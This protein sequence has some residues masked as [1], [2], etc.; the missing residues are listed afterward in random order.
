MNNNSFK[1]IFSEEY[2]GYN[3][4]SEE[5]KNVKKELIVNPQKIVVKNW[6]EDY[7]SKLTDIFYDNSE[8][9]KDL[10]YSN[11]FWKLDFSVCDKEFKEK[12]ITF[13]DKLDSWDYSIDLI[14]NNGNLDFYSLIKINAYD[15]EL[16][17][18]DFHWNDKLVWDNVM[19]IPVFF[20]IIKNSN[21]PDLYWENEY[22]IK[23]FKD[24]FWLEV[25]NIIDREDEEYDDEPSI[26][27]LQINQYYWSNL[28][29]E[30]L[31]SVIHSL[32]LSNDSVFEYWFSKNKLIDFI[33]HNTYNNSWVL[34]K[35]NAE[36]ILGEELKKYFKKANND[37]LKTY[38]YYSNLSDWARKY[39]LNELKERYLTWK[40]EYL[41]KYSISS[42]KNNYLKSNI[43]D[44]TPNELETFPHFIKESPEFEKRILEENKDN[45][46][47]LSTFRRLFWNNLIAVNESDD[48]LKRTDVYS[49]FEFMKE[50]LS[51][52]E[53]I[54]QVIDDPIL[55]QIK[56]DI[57]IITKPLSNEGEV[58][59][60]H[61]TNDF[62]S[63]DAYLITEEWIINPE[64][65]NEEASFIS[66]DTSTKYQKHHNSV[67]WNWYKIIRT[68]SPWLYYIEAWYRQNWFW[69][70]FRNVV[71]VWNH[72]V[73]E[74]EIETLNT[75]LNK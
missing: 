39:A 70:N 14:L 65:T 13:F 66:L 4:S 16:K 50:K 48:Y 40:N 41:E 1:N 54:L 8:E 64:H 10:L 45:E 68:S 67:R 58:L 30:E 47:V 5:I 34:E 53:T 19:P 56:S 42:K 37:D 60:M 29:D 9:N 71:I 72:K 11:T 36:E 52:D 63:S 62:Q 6:I 31:N 44:I 22:F 59:I 74:W 51:W 27:E 21:W 55:S 28:S 61:W 25:E 18:T 32:R 46:W 35:E 20:D 49:N 33:F 43:L 73:T 24:N 7:K 3:T 15:E 17:L 23:Y 12:N 38:G 69:E 75:F 26:E 2:L 57:K